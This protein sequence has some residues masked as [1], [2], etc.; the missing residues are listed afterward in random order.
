MTRGRRVLWWTLGGAA[1]LVLIAIAVPSVAIETAWGRALTLRIVVAR[2]NASLAGRGTLRVAHIDGGFRTPIVADSVT[3]SDA[4]GTVALSATRVELE[5]DLWSALRQQVRVTRLTLTHPF[6][7]LEEGA[8]GRWNLG[9]IF[10]SGAAT[11]PSGRS[12]LSVNID[13]VTITDGRFELVQRETGTGRVTRR[14]FDHVEIALGPTRAVDPV[15]TDG[16]AF[17]Q[18]LA[19]DLNEPPVRLRSL[20]GR[21]RWW[22]DSLALDVPSFQLP[23]SHGAMNGVVAWGVPGDTKVDLRA[24]IDTLVVSDVTWISPLLPK[25]GRG[26]T[27][28]H[29]HNGAGRGVMAYALSEL[30]VQADQ[31][32]IGGSLTAEVGGGTALRD[33]ALEAK[34]V[35][36]A[37]VRDMFGA[38]IPKKPWAGYVEGK[39]RGPG[40][41][42]S[43][44][45]F[46]SIALTWHDARVPGATGRVYVGGTIDASATPTVLHALAIDFAAL[47]IRTLGAVTA[48]ADSLHGALD[49]RV[50]LDG[51]VKDFR[52]HDLVAHHSDGDLP[53]SRISGEGRFATDVRTQ[54]LEANLVLDTI[55]PATLLRDR[56]ALPLRGMLTGTFA[57]RAT[58]DSMTLAS[59][60]HLGAGTV[61]FDGTTRLDSTRSAL[62]GRAVLTAVDPRL[63]IDRRDIPALRLSGTADLTVEGPVHATETHVLLALDTTSLIGGSH[64]RYASVRAGFDTSGFHVDTAELHA[65]DWAVSARGRLARTGATHDTLSLTAR[66]AEADSLRSLLL[67][68]A[69]KAMLDTLHGAFTASGTLVGS[70]EN[71]S[72]D[73]LAGVHDASKGAVHVRDLIAT[74]RLANL[75]DKGTGTASV[76]ASTI[77]SGTFSTT[78]FH[79]DAA[80]RDGRTARLQM[81]VESGDSLALR[82][83][84]DGVH[85][86]DSTRV[87]L[88]SLAMTVG[89]RKWRLE[90][91]AVTRMTA[92]LMEIEP[93]TMLSSSGASLRASLRLPD[94]GEIAGAMTLTNMRSVEM[95]LSDLFPPDLEFRANATVAMR[96][97]RNAPVIDLAAAIDSIT[98]GADK[99][100]KG[101]LLTATMAYANRAADVVFRAVDV[102]G[103]DSLRA[104][105]RFPVDLSLR[106]VD[107]RQLE[108][109]LQ[110]DVRA[111]NFALA[112]LDG[113]VPY[114]GGLAGRLNADVRLAG[115]WKQLEPTG[116]VRID[117]GAF[118]IAR[119]G[120][121]A[122]HLA[123]DADLRPDSITLRRLSFK[124]D[125][126]G[127]D[128]MSAQGTLVRRAG[129]WQVN[130]TSVADGFTVMDD[131]RFLEAVANWRLTLKGP[132][133]QPTL[134]GEM[135]LP[136]AVFVIND[137][138]RVRAVIDEKAVEE[139]D[140]K[141]GMPIISGL[142]V[143]LG[144]DVRLK[145]SAANVQL[146]GTI[147]IAGQVNNP[148]LLGEV[149]ASRGTYRVDLGM[150]KR[151]FRVDSGTVRVAGTKDQAASLD[152]YASYLVRGNESDAS[153]DVRIDAHLTG[154]STAPQLD[155]SSDLGSGVG[156]SEIISYLIFGSPSFM[157]D[158]Q[159]SSTVKTATAALVPSLGG[160]LEGV[161]GSMLPFFSSLQVTTVAGNGPQNLM[162]SPLDGVL[163]SFGISGG[164]QIG[165]DGFLT[166]S[167]G[168]CSGSQLASTQSPS[169]WFGASLEYRPR[170]GFGATASIDP[171]P[172]PCNSV[173][174]LSRVYQIGL[175]VF[176]EFRWR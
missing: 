112:T 163:N 44:L 102:T 19:F 49:G 33:F 151:T 61:Q 129:A 100:Q 35:N 172:S 117:D 146:G 131:P 38:D 89:S 144:N 126:T 166:L 59:L 72:L 74:A 158:G 124:D 108:S 133:K 51:P 24:T 10:S 67:D 15:R 55:M 76:T 42:L 153:R 68:S 98:I 119:A 8:D 52:F 134:S 80:I 110:I 156:D 141:V 122:R 107:Q 176:R 45:V 159:G 82:V 32:R 149:D 167:G 34:P 27:K 104:E 4:S 127:R 18:R 41:P 11:T 114:F 70:M 26:S 109:P 17:I 138:R 69:G 12:A 120:F 123:L 137:E 46:D 50:V 111:W 63:L 71:F 173:G 154:F 6:V 40:G 43:A 83:T 93:F 56:T 16:D 130:A 116:S 161:L 84:G 23:A 25:T 58:G 94:A 164:R 7:H 96:G 39:I 77:S 73:A 78:G 165:A 53:R 169:G 125:D 60:L 79:A 113:S 81:S 22:K 86:G 29:V 30:D 106:S 9:R 101:P 92:D 87:T 103:G 21:L 170:L 168:R 157:L 64:V 139:G 171:G 132:L 148:Y 135:T 65:A 54:W 14:T 2:V 99:K 142:K 150:L 88:D 147:E 90:K 20:T 136:R 155:L 152:I 62:S 145:S 31:S 160:L 115:T 105:G 37:L 13:G 118:E 128:S 36:L 91:P 57:A 3:V 85:D 1:L 66:F 5:T 162:A 48:T 140:L 95:S 28:L 143:R 97:T 121:S 175:D 174:R 47:D 75:P